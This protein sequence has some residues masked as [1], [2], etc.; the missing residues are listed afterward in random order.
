LQAG[1]P[2]GARLKSTPDVSSPVGI[3]GVAEDDDESAW[4]AFVILTVNGGS[5]SLKVGLYRAEASP[6]RVAHAEMD[7]ANGPDPAARIRDWALGHAGATPIRAVAHRLVHG[8]DEFQD[9]TLITPATLDA[10]KL[11][12]PL[13][14]NHLPGELALLESLAG[15]MT[16][17]AHV[18]CFDTAFHRTLPDLARTLP[19]PG[20]RR[21]GFHGL[22]Y[23]FLIG[24][25]ERVAGR[26]A[27]HGRVVLA[28]LGSGASI[29][30]VHEGRSIDTSMGMTPAGG[31]LM[32]TRSGDVDPGA[33][34]FV[35]RQQ[36][37]DPDEMD[38]LLTRDSGLA[39]IS[40]GTS[41]MRALLELVPHDARA[42]L[43]VDM[44]CYQAAK[45]VGAFA[46]ALGGLDTVVFSAGIGERSPEVRGR[47]LARLAF[48]GVEIDEPANADNAPVISS[49][50]SRVT[51]RVIPT[52]E[53]QVMARQA[54]DVLASA[55]ETSR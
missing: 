10:L 27:A 24:E 11:L 31:L 8:G 47:I 18:G 53:A 12:I 20:V 5:S 52:D 38:R 49:H 44:F 6:V 55:S 1:A 43:A 28:H 36:R 45:W 37:L 46:A 4:A 40:G 50:T 21:F 14:P 9:A 33:V 13:A 30:A 22:S 23:T 26:D 39:A 7:N 51:V 17:S 48:L 32:S 41:D 29:T 16:E 34:T 35:M 3:R 2:Q 42:R 15:A 25:L 54:H 19:L